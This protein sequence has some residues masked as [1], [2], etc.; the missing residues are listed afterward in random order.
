MKKLSINKNVL[1][2]LKSDFENGKPI[3]IP[4]DTNYNFLC[5]PFNQEA[6]KRVFEYKH[7][8][9]DK[10]LSLFFYD[11]SVI[12]KYA[13][14]YNRD[15]LKVIINNYLPGPL[16][17]ILNKNTSKFD[18]ILN[19]SN[20]IAF[21]SVRNPNWRRV[22]KYLNSPVAIT[23]ANISGTADTQLVTEH[24]LINQMHG[25]LSYYIEDVQN[26]NTQS[27]TIIKIENNKI[28]LIR[29]GDIKIVDILKTLDQKGYQYEY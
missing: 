25:K 19:G 6:I 28:I 20:S 21:G 23:S 5:D 29:E 11:P 16:N 26:D 22:V 17:I 18:L 12:Y 7:R 14:D 24:M 10:P 27:S 9:F 4:T 2:Q 15:I 13:K 1:K 3:A 8:S